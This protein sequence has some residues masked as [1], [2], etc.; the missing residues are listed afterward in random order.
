[1]LL[2]KEAHS[3]QDLS[4]AAPGC[5]ETL[6]EVRVLPLEFLE[7]FR[8]DLCRSR[9]SIDCLHSRFGLEGAPAESR[10]LIPKVPHE[11]LEVGECF[12]FRTFVV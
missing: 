3:F 5:L 11:L 9:R 4:R 2:P 6:A 12:F 7:P 1:M 10:Q 8:S